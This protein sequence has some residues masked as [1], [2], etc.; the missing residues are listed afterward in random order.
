MPTSIITDWDVFSYTLVN[1]LSRRVEV[2]L[3][4]RVGQIMSWCKPCEVQK[5]LY[6]LCGLSLI[7][8]LFNAYSQLFFSRFI[9][10]SPRKKLLVR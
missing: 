10:K 8:L 7:T 2:L 9:L 5:S 1:M 4:I 6:C 3:L